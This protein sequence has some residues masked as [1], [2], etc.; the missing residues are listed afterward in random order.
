MT[1]KARHKWFLREWRVFRG[2]SQEELGAMVGLHKGDIS[3]LE[4][5]KR[6]Y[7]QDQIERLA[8]ALGCVPGDLLMR[9]PAAPEPPQKIW[10]RIPE[11]DRGKALKVLESFAEVYEADTR[12]GKK[13]RR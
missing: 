4:T 10:S 13:D 5:G 3:N 11:H 2:L 1:K 6:R 9:D 8:D 7:N 12:N